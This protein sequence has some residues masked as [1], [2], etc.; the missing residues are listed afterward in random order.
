M[1]L[2]HFH[3][4]GLPEG[5]E[6]TIYIRNE[7]GNTLE[8]YA[9]LSGIDSDWLTIISDMSGITSGFVTIAYDASAGFSRTAQLLINAQDVKNG[10]QLIDLTQGIE[11]SNV[12]Q[13][14]FKKGWNL[15]SLYV[16]PINK[17]LTDVFA[18]ALSLIEEV[19]SSKGNVYKPDIVD[20]DFEIGIGKAVWVKVLE[21]ISFQVQ[22]A[23]IEPKLTP[24]VLQ[25][26]QN[27]VSFFGQ[28]KTVQEA[29]QSI[30]H[31]LI[32]VKTEMDNYKPTYSILNSLDLMIPGKG[33]L[34]EVSERVIL[35]YPED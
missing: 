12:Q 34:I 5:G 25:A 18:P 9:Q 6:F 4:Y 2:F 10:E 14:S 28:P 35:T 29:L 27:W 19:R 32:L 7:C 1:K 13:M 24:I 21:D 22:G 26:G 8:W 11:L 17:N 16:N 30:K 15:V 3:L 23:L 20:S 31:S 33:Y